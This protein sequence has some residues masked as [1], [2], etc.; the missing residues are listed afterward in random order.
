M[1]DAHL[2]GA[3][4][5]NR[6]CSPL[7]MTRPHLCVGIEKVISPPGGPQLPC[8]LP[9]PLPPGGIPEPGGPGG[10]LYKT[11]IQLTWMTWGKQNKIFHPSFQKGQL[12]LCCQMVH[13][14]T[15][16]KVFS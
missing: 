15:T 12:L 4:E 16:V 11:R 5:E 2:L 10:P 8:P 7:P 1:L 9:L 6:R 14:R 3:T 13:L